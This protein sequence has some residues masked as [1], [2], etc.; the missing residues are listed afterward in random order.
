MDDDKK[1]YDDLLAE[2]KMLQAYVTNL[3]KLTYS[4]SRDLTKYKNAIE[5]F[6]NAVDGEPIGLRNPHELSHISHIG[7]SLSA[8]PSSNRP[9][10]YLP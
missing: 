10:R 1:S 6:N 8:T 3:R 2:N 9:K 4:Q 7:R 5:A